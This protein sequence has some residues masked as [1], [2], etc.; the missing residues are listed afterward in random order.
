MTWTMNFLVHLSLSFS[1]SVI[2]AAGAVGYF[3]TSALAGDNVQHTMMS[4]A[5]VAL[6]GTSSRQG[7]KRFTWP[8]KRC[9]ES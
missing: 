2:A 4:A 7:P 5:R 9:V 3:E 8:W 1:P 6:S